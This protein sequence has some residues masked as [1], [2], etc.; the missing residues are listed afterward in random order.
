MINSSAIQTSEYISET[1]PAIRRTIRPVGRKQAKD[2]MRLLPYLFQFCSTRQ[3]QTSRGE[4]IRQVAQNQTPAQL[5]FFCAFRS[6]SDQLCVVAMRS[7]QV[8]D[9]GGA[10]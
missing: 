5:K 10:R 8:D 9:R 1:S 2:P 6:P 7:W 3:S 4:M